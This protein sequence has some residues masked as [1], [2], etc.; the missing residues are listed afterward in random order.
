[1]EYIKINYI[2][3]KDEFMKVIKRK[4]GGN[5]YTNFAEIPYFI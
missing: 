5:N 4:G 1:M 2:F 3:W